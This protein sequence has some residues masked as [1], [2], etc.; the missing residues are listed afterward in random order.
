KTEVYALSR[1]INERSL[2]QNGK[3]LIPLST[4]EKAPS[5]ELRPNQ[6]DEDSLPPYEKLDE[7]LSLYLHEKLSPDAIV[8]RG[9]EKGLVDGIINSVTRTEF[10]RQQLP[11]ILKITYDPAG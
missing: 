6:K 8:K 1:R 7:I 4:I 11:P 3:V 2:S 5:A 9:W 10:K